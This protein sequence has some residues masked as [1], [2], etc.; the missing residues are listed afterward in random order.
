MK[1]FIAF[2][3]AFFI[4]TSVFAGDFTLTSSAYKDKARIPELYTC[5]GRNISPP[6]AWENPPDGT[7]AYALVFT[8]PDWSAGPVY[9]W[10]VYN[11]PKQARAFAEGAN[12]RL[13]DTIIVAANYYNTDNYSGPCPPDSKTRNYV[14]TLYALDD[15]LDVPSNEDTEVIMQDIEKHTLGKA[16]LT[17][18]FS[19]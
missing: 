6:L 17:G 18:F 12:S 13:P 2:F 3:I 9:M 11:I 19:H 1:N 5:D 4:S 15:K 10:I 7:A 16:Q 8:S 14:F